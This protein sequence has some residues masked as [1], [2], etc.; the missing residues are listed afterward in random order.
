MP[1][2]VYTDTG[3]G[4]NRHEISRDGIRALLHISP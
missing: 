1:F 3:G 4:Y 2:I